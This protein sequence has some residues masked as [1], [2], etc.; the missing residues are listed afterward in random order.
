MV[1]GAPRSI[2]EECAHVATPCPNL[3]DTGGLFLQILVY[4]SSSAVTAAN[5]GPI[6]MGT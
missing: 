3:S 2:L 1:E 4:M 6:D 5:W